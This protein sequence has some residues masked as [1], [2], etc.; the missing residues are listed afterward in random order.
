MNVES[1]AESGVNPRPEPN[2]RRRW[3]RAILVTAALLLVAVLGTVAAIPWIVSLPPSQRWLANRAKAWF[4]PGRAEFEMVTVFWNRPTVIRGVALYDPEGHRVLA[5]PRA[6]LSLNLW[7][8]LVAR[9]PS[10]DLHFE[11]AVLDLERRADGRVNLIESIRPLLNPHPSHGLTIR[12]SEG[13]LAF[14]QEGIPDPILAERADID[15]NLAAD[16]NPIQWDVRLARPAHGNEPVASL[17]IQ[18]HYERIE[19]APGQP[20]DLEVSAHGIAWRW[21]WTRDDL[22]IEGVLEGEA[23][24]RRRSGRWSTAG[25]G[26][27]AQLV[28]SGDR[29]HGD[30]P[31]LDR[32]AVSWDAAGAG[33]SW[34]LASLDL[35]SPVGTLQAKGE[36]PTAGPSD[37]A[38][39]LEGHLDLAALGALLPHTLHLRD[40]LAIESGT[41]QLQG[42]IKPGALEGSRI[43]SIAAEVSNLAARRGDD[44]LALRDPAT[45][46]AVVSTLASPSQLSL[47]RLRLKTPF[48]DASGQGN[49]DDGLVVSAS[50]DLARGREQLGDWIDLKTA[51]LEGRGSLDGRYRLEGRTFAGVIR[52]RIESLRASGLFVLPEIARDELTLNLE[53]H[54]GAEPSGWPVAWRAI[55]V[56][57]QSGPD[58]LSVSLSKK[59]DGPGLAML[60]RLQAAFD[61]RKRRATIDA[62]IDASWHESKL[63]LRRFDLA[64]ASKELVPKETEGVA[65]GGAVEAASEAKHWKMTGRFDADQGLLT[66]VPSSRP[67]D[68]ALPA[69]QLANEGLVVA[70]LNSPNLNAFRLAASFEGDLTDAIRAVSPSTDRVSRKDSEPVSPSPAMAGRWAA[71]IRLDRSAESDWNIGLRADA[72]DLARLRDDGSLEA[73]GQ[74]ASASLR[75]LYRPGKDRLSISEIALIAPYVRLDGSGEVDRVGEDRAIV[76]EGAIRPDW[77]ALGTELARRVEPRARIAGRSRSWKLIGNL[78][79]TDPSQWPN[80]LEAEAGIELDLLDVFG[81]RLEQTRLVARLH[82]GRVQFDPIDATLNQGQ[83]HV[84]AELSHDDQGRR[85]IHLGPETQLVGAEVNDEV[86]HRVLSFAAPV[87]DQA[88]RVHGRVSVDLSDAVLPLVD[89]TGKLKPQ[90][91]GDV[92]FDDVEFVPGPLLNQLIDL[93]NLERR[94]LLVLNEPVSLSIADRR[95]YQEGLSIPVGRIAA[96]GFEGWVD[97]DRNLNL[98]ATVTLTPDQLRNIPVVTPIFQGTSVSIPIRGTLD[99]PQVDNKALGESLKAMGSGLLD[100]TLSTTTSGMIQGLSELRNLFSRRPAFG[101]GVNPEARAVPRSPEPGLLKDP[102]PPPPRR[103]RPSAEERRARRLEKK[104]ERMR[105]RGQIP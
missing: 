79:G 93:L 70:G 53:A 9:P 54:G 1:S 11:R 66:L 22:K 61:V 29:L 27:L 4:A 55:T 28:A 102:V 62:V 25:D 81:M 6:R 10:A 72:T 83:L 19:P 74:A 91:D 68:A 23:S 14:R 89:T 50:F 75:A 37:T 18:G 38:T 80:T 96:V 13:T 43:W 34:N 36:I 49:L 12:V 64:I 45:L 46:E 40:D 84:E 31:A 76:M 42:T 67:A 21:S 92:H 33:N 26:A 69:I 5:S 71:A 15:L 100:R 95:V 60:S 51:E 86:S 94:P 87:L 101:G 98:A 104:L 16:P 39:T 88:T 82:Q 59:D 90:V 35:R 48:V 73:T 58:R 63:D 97:F 57:S 32:V 105:K 8:I 2:R 7:Q 99:E 24:G 44:R 47:D 85:W 78:T 20:H 30:H 17:Q 41:A 52:G 77:E 3:G 103:I 65:A 56:D